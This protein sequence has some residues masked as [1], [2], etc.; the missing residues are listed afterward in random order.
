MEKTPGQKDGLMTTRC[1]ECKAIFDCLVKFD[2]KFAKCPKC[3]E[4]FTVSMYRPQSS[5]KP[6][7]KPKSMVI[8]PDRDQPTQTICGLGI[9]SIAMG[10]VACVTCWVPLVGGVSI[11]V[12]I[13][14]IFFGIAGG[15]VAMA[16]KRT[17]GYL[18]GCGVF[19]CLTAVVVFTFAQAWF[20]AEVDRV[21]NELKSQFSLSDDAAGWQD[22]DILATAKVIDGEICVTNGNSY[23][24]SD[25][26]ITLNGDYIYKASMIPGR[27]VSR[28]P[29]YR[30]KASSG[31]G[32]MLSLADYDD[33]DMLI[34]TK[35]GD[36]WIR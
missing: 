10:V 31:D 34:E 2:G 36:C 32:G 24:W 1:A 11:P 14:G 25:V 35:T 19:V 9:A 8:R 13:L 6:P 23:A 21:T 17:D 3:G 29:I 16:T 7:I 22:S 20:D 18:A 33:L 15:V 30:F 26:C 28:I 4:R 12:A 5:P 27:A